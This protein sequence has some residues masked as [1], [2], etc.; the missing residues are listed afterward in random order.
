[1]DKKNNIEDILSSQELKENPF[2]VPKGYF[3][4]MKL[5]VM[6]K[7]SAMGPME[8]EEVEPAAPVTFIAYLKPAISLAAVFAIVFG[9]GYGVM[10]I[11]DTYTPETELIGEENVTLTDEEEFISILNITLEDIYTA[12]NHPHEEASGTIILDEEVIEQ[13]LIDSGYPST[14]IAQLE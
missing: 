3:D 1:M 7:I 6:K 12:D 11:T 8:Q 13:Y 4:T 2:G 14:A 10:K 5:E 9:M